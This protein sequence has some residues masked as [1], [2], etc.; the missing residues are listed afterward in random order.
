MMFL[1]KTLISA[2]V[3]AGASEIAKRSNFWSSILISLP[4]VSVLTLCW[5]YYEQR[6]L[7]QIQNLSMG[8]LW[9]VIPSLLF[10][11]V[12]SASLK[13]GV[14]FPMSLLI[15]CC[16]TVVAYLVWIWLLGRLGIRI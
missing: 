9:A 4:L 1:V 10:F 6:N 15:S 7:G 3:I 8:I 5:A 13:Y 12:L 11:V 2:L 16:S 14:N